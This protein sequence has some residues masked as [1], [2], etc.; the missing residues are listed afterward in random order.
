MNARNMRDGYLGLGSYGTVG[1]ELV[2]SILFGFLAG[3]WIDQKLG[4][5]GWVTLLGFGLGTVAGF[6][7][8]YRAAVR[9]RAESDAQD[10]R[11]RRQTAGKTPHGGADGDA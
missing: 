2:L 7:S 10:E 6:R 9:M 5:G 4:A 11:E 3:R 1:L 8:V